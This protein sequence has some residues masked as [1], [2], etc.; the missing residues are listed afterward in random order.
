M[1]IT[2]TRHVKKLCA[3]PVYCKYCEGKL[4]VN[5]KG[6]YCPVRH[7]QWEHGVAG[8]TIEKNRKVVT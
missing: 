6:H 1:K 7:C 5:W 3:C 4:R 2:T 8:C